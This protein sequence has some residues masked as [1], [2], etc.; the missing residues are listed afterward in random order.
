MPFS[1]S[2]KVDITEA[3]KWS[4]IL[5]SE[6]GDNLNTLESSLTSG[7]SSAECTSATLESINIFKAVLPPSKSL[8]SHTLHNT[9]P[10]IDICDDIKVN[11]NTDEFILD[12]INDDIQ[13]NDEIKVNDNTDEVILDQIN[14][15]KIDMEL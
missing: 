12:Q 6:M 10:K 4:L 9:T 11:D 14:K 1:R 8:Q 15:F 2:N 13:I 7:A 5:E 3:L